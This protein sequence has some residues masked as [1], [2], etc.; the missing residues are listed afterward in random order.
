MKNFFLRSPYS[1]FIFILNIKD[2]FPLGLEITQMISS[3]DIIYS[4]INREKIALFEWTQI[5]ALDHVMGLQGQK[6]KC[7]TPK[8]QRF[9]EQ[10]FCLFFK[11]VNNHFLTFVS[12]FS[13]SGLTLNK[14]VKVRSFL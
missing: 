4:K 13:F 5:P 3:E 12:R 7:Y 11:I 10:K 14:L 8:G 1:A 9:I 2:G 6:Y